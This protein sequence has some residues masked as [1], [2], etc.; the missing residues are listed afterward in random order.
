[1]SN[2]PKISE[3][4]WEIMKEIWRDHPATAEQIIERLPADIEWTEQTVRTF[5]NRLLKKKAISKS[6]RSYRYFPLVQEAECKRAES[7]SFLKRVFNRAVG[8]MMTNFLEDVQL[9][10][11]K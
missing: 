1:M 10:T 5:L 8:T 11:K 6:G 7:E 4:E 2:I 3:A 9:S